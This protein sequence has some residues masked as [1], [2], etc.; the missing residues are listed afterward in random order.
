[1]RQVAH[2]RLT[3]RYRLSRTCSVPSDPEVVLRDSYTIAAVSRSVRE[4][5][6]RYMTLPPLLRCTHRCARYDTPIEEVFNDDAYDDLGPTE[7]LGIAG[8]EKGRVQIHVARVYGGKRRNF[9]GQN[10]WVRGFFRIDGRA[11]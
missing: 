4:A 6:E 10:F 9:V 5:N 1:M 8:D 11:G 7:V 3:A 2:C